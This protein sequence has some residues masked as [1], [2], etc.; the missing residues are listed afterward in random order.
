MNNY[1]LIQQTPPPP[2][3]TLDI[4]LTFYVPSTADSKNQTNQKLFNVV[5]V[6]AW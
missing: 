3:Q 2:P 4:V 1:S 6:H 5:K